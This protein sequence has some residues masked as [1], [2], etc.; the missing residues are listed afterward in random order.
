VGDQINVKE[1]VT[2]SALQEVERQFD[3]R[4]KKGQTYDVVVPI[5]PANSSHAG[6]QPVEG[7]ATMRITKVVPQGGDKYVEAKIVENYIA[8]G[9]EPGGPN[10][11]TWAGV[12]KMVQ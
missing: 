4:E 5:I 6:W 7:F 1:G 11:G 2:D 9:M 12:P 8:P 3:L 10:F